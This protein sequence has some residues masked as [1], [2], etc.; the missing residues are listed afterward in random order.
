MRPDLPAT[1]QGQ[2]KLPNLRMPPKP[3]RLRKL[4]HRR[5]RPLHPPTGPFLPDFPHQHKRYFLNRGKWL[6]L[7]GHLAEHPAAGFQDRQVMGEL[8]ETGVLFYEVAGELGV[9]WDRVL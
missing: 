2:Q 8:E 5:H 1:L 4:N 7:R 3:F 6:D 9:A